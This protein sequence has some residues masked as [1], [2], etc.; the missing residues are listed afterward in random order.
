M[1]KSRVS[2]RTSSWSS[3]LLYG[4]RL[5][6]GTS[7]REVPGLFCRALFWAAQSHYPRRRVSGLPVSVL[8]PG[9]PRLSP[10]LLC[11]VRLSLCVVLPARSSSRPC[12]STSLLTPRLPLSCLCPASASVLAS[13][14][15]LSPPHACHHFCLRARPTLVSAQPFSCA[16]PC[17]FPC[18][19]PSLRPTPLSS[20]A[21]ASASPP[22][23]F[24]S[25]PFSLCPA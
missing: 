6:P 7:R 20:R 2:R 17:V 3:H 13:V 9:S 21:P 25:C 18:A 24:P 14:S 11:F 10:T 4:F 8:Q 12:F 23:A 1:P 19:N 22:P 5:S 15:R 16:S